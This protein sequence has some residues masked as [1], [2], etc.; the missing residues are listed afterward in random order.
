MVDFL[1][2]N[3]LIETTISSAQSTNLPTTTTNFKVF[4]GTKTVIDFKLRDLDS[5]VVNLTGKKVI[6]NVFSYTTNEFQFYKELNI[7]DPIRGAAQ[8]VFDIIDTID[9]MAGYFYYSL[10]SVDQDIPQPYYIDETANALSYFELVEGV[11][12]TPMPTVIATPDVYTPMT[13]TQEGDPDYYVAG[14]YKGDSNQYRDDGLHTVVVYGDDFSGRFYIQVSLNDEPLQDDWA[15]IW[16]EELVPWK[17]Y[18]HFSSIEPFNFKA[19]VK[20]VRFKM[21]Q[22]PGQ[23]GQIKKILYRN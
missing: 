12:P 13:G 9:L 21:I 2:Y 19:N 22:S 11:M 10:T 6:L 7:T 14:P 3:Q 15:N 18:D 1:S 4:K 23:T 16:L 20:W 8:A 17:N 5:Q